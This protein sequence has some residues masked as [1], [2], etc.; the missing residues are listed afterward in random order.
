M[1][2]SAV[3]LRRVF[4]PL[5]AL[6]LAGGLAAG[7]VAVQRPPRV[8]VVLGFVVP[9]PEGAS[10][11][12][13]SGPGGPDPVGAADLFVGTLSGWLASPDFA[14]AVFRRAS[15]PVPALSIRKLGRVFE[16]RRRG[17]QVVDVRFQARSAD[18]AARIAKA[19]REE[20]A[21][22][23]TA[24]AGGNSVLSFR[25]IAGEPLVVPVRSNAALRGLVVG[26]VLLVA[27]VNIVFLW[28]FL[29]SPSEA[30]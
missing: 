19:V 23:A 26:V 13:S 29:R 4:W 14:A 27:G 6:G 20:V 3:L 9:I 5:L 7:V 24:F 16:A 12:S 15:L 2:P 18:D 11:R 21:E 25:A 22:R 30:S 28:D 17:G 10:A 1:T 8:D